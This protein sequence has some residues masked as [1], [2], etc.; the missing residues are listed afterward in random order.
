MTL[1]PTFISAKVDVRVILVA[2]DLG[3]IHLRIGSVGSRCRVRD[4]YRRR[5][6]N[7]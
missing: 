6:Y 3:L 5:D 4:A 2:S 7:V 1:L